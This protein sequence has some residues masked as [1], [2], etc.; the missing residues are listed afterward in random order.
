MLLFC[1]WLDVQKEMQFKDCS[2]FKLGQ[3]FLVAVRIW[4]GCDEEFVCAIIF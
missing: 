1:S 2:F 3:S 4:W